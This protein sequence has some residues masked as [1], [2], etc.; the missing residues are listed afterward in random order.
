MAD[1]LDRKVEDELKKDIEKEVKEEIEEKLDKK[2]D[3][4]LE[5]ELKQEID[6]EVK[7][8]FHHR[9]YEQTKKSAWKFQKEFRE[10]IAIAVTAAF[11]FLIALSWRTPIQESIDKLIEFLGL[12][13]KV[14]Y[15]EFF[16][17]LV[18]TLIAVLVLMLVSKW[19]SEEK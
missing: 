3:G 18:V 12:T 1:E 2:L 10:Q 19:K 17:A 5:K 13:G 11:A 15:M 7:K 16:S 4:K 6:K 8:R 9:I 14:V